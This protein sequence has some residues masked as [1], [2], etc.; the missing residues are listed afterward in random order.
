MPPRGGKAAAA[1][2]VSP[3]SVAA[4]PRVRARARAGHG[5]HSRQTIFS[6]LYLR[7][8]A[9]TAVEKGG[10]RAQWKSGRGKVAAARL[11]ERPTQRG[12]RARAGPPRTRGLDHAAAQAQDE[13]QRGLLL[14][15]VVRQRAACDR[16]GGTRARRRL[17]WRAHA[18]ATPWR[19]RADAQKHAPSSSCLPAKI[20]RCWSGGMPSLSWIL[21]FTLRAPR[22]GRGRAGEGRGGWRVASEW[23]TARAR[24]WPRSTRRRRP[25]AHAPLDRIGR[26]DIER[27]SLARQGLHEDLQ[28]GE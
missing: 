19:R 17:G 7:A 22:G 15:V 3:L 12:A 16:D 11:P 9:A 5:T 28:E 14:D 10:K 21:A 26:L 25:T 6:Q 20:R 18:R 8:S 4:S 24:A 23:G 27:N 2:R 1:Q 13:V